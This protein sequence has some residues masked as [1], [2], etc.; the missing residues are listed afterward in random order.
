MMNEGI[1]IQREYP[2]I[3]SEGIRDKENNCVST[4]SRKKRKSRS[5]SKGIVK[6]QG[7][8]TIKLGLD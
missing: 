7:N 2:L 3:V 5:E 4:I 8:N 6:E 1:E